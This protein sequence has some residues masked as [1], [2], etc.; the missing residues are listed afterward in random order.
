MTHWS[1]NSSPSKQKNAACE[2]G[3]V[4]VL[5]N[6]F[7]SDQAVGTVAIVWRMRLAIL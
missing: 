6:R 1:A 3:G 4:F 2:T 7:P 5:L